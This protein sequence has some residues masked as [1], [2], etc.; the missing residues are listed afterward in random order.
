MWVRNCQRPVKLRGRP[1]RNQVST[2]RALWAVVLALTAV[3]CTPGHP[4]GVSGEAALRYLGWRVVSYRG[5]QVQVPKAWPV[6][7]GNHTGSCGG[8][9]PSTPTAFLGPD[10]NGA[11]S[12]GAVGYGAKVP[13]PPYGV[14]LSPGAPQV[15]GHEIHP[16]RNLSVYQEVPGPPIEIIEY[17]GVAVD[18]G[19]GPD[20]SVARRILDSIRYVSG[21]PDTPRARACRVSNRPQQM[22]RPSRLA[23][24]IVVNQGN[25]TLSP[26]LPT[27]QPRVSAAVIWAHA[28][29][30]G[31]SLERSQ[32]LLTR[33]S[34][35]LPAQLE[36]NGSLVP[37]DQNV[38]AWVVYTSP[39][40]SRI[41]GCGGWGVNAYS[42]V[43]GQQ[44]FDGGWSPGP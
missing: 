24:T 38:L 19:M 42:A 14:W 31:P 39:L 11:P 41:P 10:L 12:C 36:P 44:I 2:G 22:P 32:L 3:G 1:R 28:A 7:D 34:A 40:S 30:T 27:D 21:A 43:T 17:H 9:F 26:P 16:T 18:I 23:S 6:V 33:Y 37:D 8:T 29:P 4:S 35:A 13:P 5:V 15:D 20:P 25:I